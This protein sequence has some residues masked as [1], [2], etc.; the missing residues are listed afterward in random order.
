MVN[1]IA[2]VDT[3][4]YSRQRLEIAKSASS[5]E[6][7]LNIGNGA[8]AV[9]VQRSYDNFV[10]SN[11]RSGQAKLSKH[12]SA[13]EYAT[14][15]ENILA[16]KQL[17]LSASLNRF[18][19]A[20][21]EVSISPSSAAARQNLLNVAETTVSQFGSVGMQLQRTE[22]DSYV[23]LGTKVNEITQYQ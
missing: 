10:V 20:V 3:K 14:Q 13:L 18:F 21:Q 16:D 2:N 9:R 1:N 15:L 8:R 19:A 23:D 5:S 22:E 4:G 7:S 11:L 17:S 6:G 12:E